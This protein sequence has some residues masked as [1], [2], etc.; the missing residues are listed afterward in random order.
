M[1]E[2]TDQPAPRQMNFSLLKMMNTL[3]HYSLKGEAPQVVEI[4]INLPFFSLFHV[5]ICIFFHSSNRHPDQP[6]KTMLLAVLYAELG[7]LSVRSAYLTIINTLYP[8]LAREKRAGFISSH[9]K[10]NFLFLI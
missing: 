1:N 6:F 7:S 3:V 4:E 5:N 10:F 2:T 8:T 9:S